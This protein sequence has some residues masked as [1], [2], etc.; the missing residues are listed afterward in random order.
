MMTSASQMCSEPRSN[1]VGDPYIHSDKS[2]HSILSQAPNCC[3]RVS[4]LDALAMGDGRS[5]GILPVETHCQ[6]IE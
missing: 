3:Q 4:R 1:W 2:G 6:I 5:L